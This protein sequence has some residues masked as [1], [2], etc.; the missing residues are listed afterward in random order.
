MS[1][2]PLNHLNQLCF[3]PLLTGIAE[4]MKLYL[5]NCTRKKVCHS[6]HSF[7]SIL[8]HFISFYFISIHNGYRKFGNYTSLNASEWAVFASLYFALAWRKFWNY[9]FCYPL[10]WS[11]FR[12]PWSWLKKIS[13]IRLFKYSRMSS[14]PFLHLIVVNFEIWNFNWEMEK[15]NF[16]A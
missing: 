15:V 8:F 1:G 6:F 3:L 4:I 9:I 16:Q 13:K 14:F 12:L 5:F 11:I 2:F 7:H 10:V